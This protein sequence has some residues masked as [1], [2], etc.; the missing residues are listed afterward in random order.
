MWWQ[1]IRDPNNNCEHLPNSQ[2][3]LSSFICSFRAVSV[4]HS[5][6][7]G[8][9]P[10]SDEPERTACVSPGFSCIYLGPASFT[11]APS[12]LIMS[13]HLSVRTSMPTYSLF[14]F[15]FDPRGPGAEAH[16]ALSDTTF[17][18][19]VLSA[20]SVAFDSPSHSLSAPSEPT[21]ASSSQPTCAQSLFSE[22]SAVS[23]PS[24]GIVGAALLAYPGT[25]SSVLWS[26]YLIW[27]NYS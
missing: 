20:V 22:S 16:L 21:A 4:S 9:M 13:H 15:Y 23:L 6:S 12:G 17:S 8:G 11:V 10:M 26:N 19:A 24:C 25:R 5:P 27:G 18:A 1:Q 7:W 2:Q 14:P 3:G